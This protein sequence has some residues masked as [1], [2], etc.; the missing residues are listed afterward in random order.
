MLGLAQNAVKLKKQYAI[1][2]KNIALS[3]LFIPLN[4]NPLF[5]SWERLIPK[6]GIFVP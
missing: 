3:L 6:L 4:G 5:P 1:N 2:N